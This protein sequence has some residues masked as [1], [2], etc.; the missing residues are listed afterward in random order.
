MLLLLQRPQRRASRKAGGK[1]LRYN[2]DDDG[3]EQ[4]SEGQSV[5]CAG[6]LGMLAGA[7][8]G[9]AVPPLLLAA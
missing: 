8:A 7:A 5:G 6:W 1:R 4:E 2:E 3:G 9:R